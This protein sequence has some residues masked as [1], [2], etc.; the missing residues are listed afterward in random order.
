MV[1]LS[2]VFFL[3]EI[4]GVKISAGGGALVFPPF[5]VCSDKEIFEDSPSFVLNRQIFRGFAGVYKQAG[6]V[7]KLEFD[8]EDFF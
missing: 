6:L 5:V 3:Q 4:G 1:E 2:C 7:Y 8:A